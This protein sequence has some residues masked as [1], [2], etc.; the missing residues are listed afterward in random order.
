MSKALLKQGE[1]IIQEI[2]RSEP[3]P[4]HVYDLVENKYKEASYF[5][6]EGSK[7]SYVFLK[8]RGYNYVVCMGPEI[9]ALSNLKFF[10]SRT[11]NKSRIYIDGG[12]IITVQRMRVA[13]IA[14]VL[15]NEHLLDTAILTVKGDDTS[16]AVLVRGLFNQQQ[17]PLIAF[18]F[19]GE[20]EH[21]YALLQAEMYCS[22]HNLSIK[23]ERKK[24]I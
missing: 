16:G 18:S 20:D 17:Y 2:Q 19:M 21:A 3:V 6:I 9:H 24:K 23:Y 10:L 14:H 4:S 15:L 5:V 8:F 13:A 12:L 11:N 7:Y 22:F 1:H